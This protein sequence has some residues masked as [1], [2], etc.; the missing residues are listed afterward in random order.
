MNSIGSHNLP[1]PAPLFGGLSSPDSPCQPNVDPVFNGGTG[2]GKPPSPPPPP[3]EP[4]S[5]FPDCA[6]TPSLPPSSPPPHFPS[7][8]PLH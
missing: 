7:R 1:P 2:F 3:P 6:Y 4:P 5:K 8:P